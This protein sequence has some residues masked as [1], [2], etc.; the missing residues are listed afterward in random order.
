MKYIRMTDQDKV[1]AIRR[2][3]TDLE[4]V[5]SIAKSIGVSRQSIWKLLQKAGIDTAKETA[6]WINVSCSACGT[7]L[8]R[9]R[10]QIRA[11]KHLFCNAA[12]YAAWLKHGNGQPLQEHRHHQRIGRSIVEKFFPLRPEHIVHHEDRNDFNNDPANLRVFCNQG[13]HVRYH[14]GF[15]VPVLWDGRNPSNRRTYLATGRE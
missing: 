13:D 10:C 3:T 7:E 8:K 12:C 15:M 6:A 5:T 1:D 2:Y 11:A 4:P 9:R 14:R